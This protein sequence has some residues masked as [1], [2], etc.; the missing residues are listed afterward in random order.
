MSELLPN[1]LELRRVKLSGDQRQLALGLLDAVEQDAVA[2]TYELVWLR[3][4]NKE[5]ARLL[6]Y[7]AVHSSL[8]PH[9][10]DAWRSD[11]L[12]ALE[13]TP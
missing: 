12:A 2:A 6:K 3:D 11:A 13:R 7:A 1:D 4:Q 8:A 9:M 5:L 10:N